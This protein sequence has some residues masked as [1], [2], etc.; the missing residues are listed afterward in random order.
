MPK[1]TTK[2][3][4]TTLQQRLELVQYKHQHP[5]SSQRQ[6][7]E[8]FYSKYNTTISQPTLSQIL[9]TPG[10]Q[11]TPAHQ[12]QRKNTKTGANTTL[13][14]ALYQWFS[15]NQY[16]VNITNDMLQFKAKELSSN[17]AFLGHLKDIDYSI[18]WLE[19][20]KKRFNI[21]SR[22]KHGEAAS[23]PPLQHSEILEIKEELSNYPPEDIYNMDETAL[24]FRLQGQHSLSTTQI[25]GSKSAK[26]RI[27][28]VLCTNSTGTHQLPLWIIGKYNNPRA[29]KGIN[30][31]RL[32]AIYKSN[33]KAWMNTILF[34]EW[35]YWLDNQVKRPI[36]LLMDNFKAHST[37]Y[38]L[39]NI[40]TLLLPPNTTAKLQPL[41]AGIIHAFKA[42]Y[43]KL[44]GLQLLQDLNKNEAK[45]GQINILNALFLASEA[46]ESVNKTT[47]FNCFK[48]TGLFRQ[49]NPQNSELDQEMQALQDSL[50]E[51]QLQLPMAIRMD[52]N[53]L[54][55]HP[56]EA[57]RSEEG[58]TDTDIIDLV[59][60]EEEEIIPENQQEI[61]PAIN[62]STA[63]QHIKELQQFVLQKLENDEKAKE[64]SIQLQKF[65][66]SLHSDQQKKAKQTKIL[67][68]FSK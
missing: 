21:K 8:W 24:F 29:F 7:Q 26:D 6:L 14:N 28:I 48:H 54:L 56:L 62:T 1:S 59:S 39:K 53:T 13:E 67:D 2:T 68:F 52:I 25:S 43:R 46:W 55:N 66:I 10:L 9:N 36:I 22:F 57:A 63:I 5:N 23:I 40:K 35:I 33:K 47:I 27:T 50:Q 61:V 51:I 58:L 60:Q 32:P 65:L 38:N 41:D 4:H 17:H 31:N 44:Y 19:R 49:Y 64:L 12:L 42:H 45:I 18:G 34:K 16:K 15:I 20:F 30:T 3:T 11:N 37:N